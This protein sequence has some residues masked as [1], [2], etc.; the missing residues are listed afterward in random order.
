MEISK[1][2]TDQYCARILSATLLETKTAVELSKEMNIPIAACYRKIRMLEKAGLLRCIEEKPTLDGKYAAA[3]K[4]LLEEA[5]ILY[6]NGK[7]K[8]HI[9]LINGEEKNLV[10]DCK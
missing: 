4:S 9:K 8:A 7:I 5:R 10:F 2:I 3:Y 1:I 6:E